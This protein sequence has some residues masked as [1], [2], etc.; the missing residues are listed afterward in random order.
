MLLSP[1]EKDV[2]NESHQLLRTPECSKEH[3]FPSGS[4]Q[5]WDGSGTP[6]LSPGKRNLRLRGQWGEASGKE[7]SNVV[8]SAFSALPEAHFPPGVV[9][10]PLPPN[11]LPS[12]P[13]ALSFPRRFAVYIWFFA[14][15]QEACIQALDLLY[16]HC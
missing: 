15:N 6:G 7:G 10:E 3:S 2:E 4:D 13:H 8:A 5:V 14:R 16:F 1:R 9:W 11:A 12:S